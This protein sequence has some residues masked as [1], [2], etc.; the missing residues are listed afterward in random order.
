MTAET[1]EVIA[2]Y[3]WRSL[4]T[5]LV[6]VFLVCLVLSNS[7]LAS[8]VA[9]SMVLLDYTP[10]GLSSYS[11]MKFSVTS[12]ACAMLSSGL[13][14]D[15]L[16]HMAQKCIKE[17]KPLRTLKT[18]DAHVKLLFIHEGKIDVHQGNGPA[19]LAEGC[20]L[21]AVVSRTGPTTVPFSMNFDDGHDLKSSTRTRVPAPTTTTTT[22]KLCAAKKHVRCF[23]R[24]WSMLARLCIVLCLLGVVQGIGLKGNGD[25]RRIRKSARSGAEA[26]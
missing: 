7:L 9:L 15:Y 21:P 6:A 11:G 1:N 24:S 17:I 25:Y 23:G 22:A 4:S 3:L 14:V 20:E 19:L 2:K 5:T 10:L 18:G 8:V 13:S 16:I 12:F 26:S